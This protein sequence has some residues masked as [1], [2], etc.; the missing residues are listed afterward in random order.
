MPFSMIA[1]I[2]LIL[3]GAGT[4]MVY[5]VGESR[6]G[7]E[8]DLSQLQ[9]LQECLILESSE[10]ERRVSDVAAETSRSNGLNNDSELQ[11]RFQAAWLDEIKRSYPER[12]GDFT[13][14]LVS[15]AMEIRFLRLSM[16]DASIVKS[17]ALKSQ[18]GASSMTLPVYV[19]ALGNYSLKAQS[20]DCSITRSFEVQKTI[21]D[22]APFLSNRL[23]SFKALFEGG[24][25]EVEN[26]VRYQLAALSQDRILRGAGSG[27]FD[28]GSASTAVMTSQDVQNA[29]NLAILVEQLNVFRAYDEAYLEEILQQFPCSDET[30]L[31]AKGVL[32]GGGQIDIADLFLSLNG[33]GRYPLNQ[34]LAQSLYSSADVLVLRWLDY[35]HIIDLARIAEQA[36]SGIVTTISDIADWLTGVD[37]VEDS[38]SRWMSDRLA[39]SG[40]HDYEYRWLHYNSP[41]SYVQI[42]MKSLIF[43]NHAGDDLE[44]II[45]GDYDIDFPS[46]DVLSSTS[47]KEFLIGYRTG[48]C[49]LATNLELFVK[50]IAMNI[51]SNANLPEIELRLD[52]RDSENYLDELLSA[53]QDIKVSS[54]AWFEEALSQSDRSFVIKDPLGQALAEFARDNWREL[55]LLNSSV[56]FAETRLA[57]SIV[58]GAVASTSFISD[59]GM[60]NEIESVKKELQEN[61][62]WGVDASIRSMFEDDIQPRLQLFD[63]VFGNLTWE[64]Q[65]TTLQRL[66]MT[67][68]S[69]VIDGIPGIKRI[70][71]NLLERQMSDLR[72]QA[73]LR[74]DKILVQL[75]DARRFSLSTENGISVDESLQ[76][77]VGVP[78]VMT[79][80][81]IDVAVVLP[82]DFHGIAEDCPNLHLTDPLNGTMCPF[83]S[84]FGSILSGVLEVKLTVAPNPDSLLSRAGVSMS[85][86]LPI[87]FQSNFS[88][89]SGWPLENVEYRPTV[90][91]DQQITRFLEGL[92]NA[93]CGAL[94][95]IGDAC[96]QIFNFLKDCLSKLLSYC[97]EA[98][99]IL[100]DFLMNLAQGL[101]DIVKGAIGS[102][103]G[104]IASSISAT[105]GHVQCVFSLGGLTMALETCIPDMEF[106]RSRD[107]LKW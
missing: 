88:C 86:V 28:V 10:L 59:T 39:E 37:M 53:V 14:N 67:L 16:D 44:V 9:A 46:F 104:G 73:E 103:I 63:R 33:G 38:M 97:M 43:Q 1:V 93:L 7:R 49:Q 99:E 52:P 77:Q 65:S 98:V 15:S 70:V 75:S 8:M 2:L 12:R 41:D 90:T 66:I 57:E 36:G 62:N 91:L 60:T 6:V 83:E 69:G 80:N 68:A 78:W 35:L 55:F 22:P 79:P 27:S 4:A 51:A 5:G 92:W 19:E 42:A 81:A 54:G 21:Y 102:L 96:S 18:M 101:R 13:V 74:C 106:G 89:S 76:V 84:G 61:G 72:D 105:L 26:L 20:L 24:K 71:N 50:S 3:A 64:G 56:D 47:W 87:A 107:L 40:I 17:S 30:R 29:L 100:S 32:L 48:T 31:E 34:I 23:Q 95:L 45:Q 11:A 94:Q 85:L 25:N 58:E 82:G